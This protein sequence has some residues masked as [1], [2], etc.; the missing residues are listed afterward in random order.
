MHCFAKLNDLQSLPEVRLATLDP[1]R[2]VIDLRKMQHA[3]L[4]AE[5][6]HFA[7]A[8]ERAHLTQSALSR[9][10]Q[11]LE[12]SLGLR[13]FDRSQGVVAQTVAGR[14]FM[15]KAQGLLRSARDLTHDMQLLRN[16]EIGE[17]AVGC[18]PFPAATL[19][20]AALADL[21]A[22]H[23][24]LCITLLIDHAAALRT[25]LEAERI[26]LFVADTRSTALPDGLSVRALPPQ[27]G[28]FFCRAKH[29]LARRRRLSLIDIA[30]ERFASVH[31]P[32]A[33]RELLHRSLGLPQN[34]SWALN[35][36]NVHVLKD[37]ARQSDVVLICTE[38]AMAA[39][40]A[41]GEF[42][43]LKLADFRPWKIA[44]G[45]VSLKGRTPSPV[46]ELLMD[47]LVTAAKSPA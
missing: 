44:A 12:A 17:L 41:S 6:L 29:P 2:T 47:R 15:A 3:A 31:I 37:L 13:L 4:L 19:M 7:R 23:P 14:Q 10:I 24:R 36:D 8:A 39:E 42:V 16:A 38:Q 46:A 33:V 34:T 35:C 21:H 26:E 43:Q 18:G 25:L 9:S 22:S 20:P 27:F 11:S 30:G 5:T 1:W 32:A 45:I 28:N 40:L